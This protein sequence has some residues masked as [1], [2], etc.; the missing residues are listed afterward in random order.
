MAGSSTGRGARGVT[1]ASLAA[2]GAGRDG[3]AGALEQ[4]A[5]AAVAAD[6]AGRDS[7]AGAVANSTERHC[8]P[9]STAAAAAE[10]ARSKVAGLDLLLL[11]LL[12]RGAVVHQG[13]QQLAW[14]ALLVVWCRTLR[15]PRCL[16]AR[17]GR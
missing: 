3:Q 5:A 4:P 14:A 2:G 12:T 11:L 13:E 6:D 10:A 17:P 8:R 1:A 7:A 16:R 15:G 9:G